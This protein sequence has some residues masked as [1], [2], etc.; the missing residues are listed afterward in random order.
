MATARQKTCENCWRYGDYVRA[1]SPEQ[2]KRIFQT[3]NRQGWNVP[4]QQWQDTPEEFHYAYDTQG[5]LLYA[6]FAMTP[7]QGQSSYTDGYPALRRALAQYQYD[8][9]GRITSLAHYWQNY[10]S[11]Y[12]STPILKQEYAYD[13]V[14]RLR[15]AA[16][17]YNNPDSDG[18]FD[19]IRTETYDYDDDLDYLTEVD[20]NDGL[21]NEAQTWTYDAAG[22]R[23]TDSVQG[24]GWSYDNL[25]R[26]LTS[27][28]Y[29]YEHDILGNRT[30]RNRQVSTGGV[31]YEWDELNRA[32]SIVGTVSGARYEYRADGMRTD[33]VE[34]FNLSWEW[35]DKTHTS[36]YYDE[37]Q[38]Q[39][40]PT[41]R[42]Y[43]DGQM[44]VEDDYTVEGQY[45]PV[46][47]VMRYGIGARGI[48]FMDKRVDDGPETKGYPIYD[49]HGNMIATL[50]QTQGSPYYS[51]ADQRS[52]D[53]WGSVR[54]GSTTG[55]PK[56]RYCAN[57]GHVQDDES[58]LI[59]MRARYYEPWS[60]RFISQ[61]PTL[62]G[63]NWF[64][65]AR[66][67]PMSYADANGQSWTNILGGALAALGMMYAAGA[68]ATLWGK[69]PFMFFSSASYRCELAT[70]EALWATMLF[71]ASTLVVSQENTAIP[72]HLLGPLSVAALAFQTIVATMNLGLEKAKYSSAASVV[73]AAY[74]YGL[75]LIGLLVAIAVEDMTS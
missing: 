5:K 33:K 53:V 64:S 43:Y 1:G 48:D 37:I 30:W 13:S 26:I 55:D 58:G 71:A 42:Y 24:S 6:A 62:F 9:A 29:V 28:G 15:T 52:Y 11:G 69:N 21:P 7:Q 20:Y 72:I 32:T 45:E 54:S 12:S 10:N 63:H 27:P 61:D 70:T 44:M 36:G 68:I 57:L 67:D 39:N 74:I 66:N 50:G 51:L 60:G 31:K 56:Q 59:Y 2:G 75:V 14:T 73:A 35:T 16:S 23:A 46:V 17:F 18:D 65:Y 38:G 40:L 19:L 49:G 3:L 8:P 34:G 4:Q 41:S 47:T 22:N 25:N